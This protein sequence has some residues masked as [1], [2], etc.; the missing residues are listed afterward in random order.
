M[1]F[2]FF[3]YLSVSKDKNYVDSFQTSSEAKRL[4]ARRVVGGHCDH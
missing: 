4:H 2:L 3:D 1:R